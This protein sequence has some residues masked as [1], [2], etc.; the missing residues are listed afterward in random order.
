MKA[1]KRSRTA[2]MAAVI[3]ALH[4]A[5]ES[6]IVFEDQFAGRLAGPVWHF[7]CKSRLLYL[8]ATRTIYKSLDPIRR[9]VLARAR[10]AEDKLEKALDLGI[11][12]YVIIGAGLDSFALR[13]SE[14]DGKINIYELDHPATQ[15]AKKA[16]LKQLNL[17]LPE[18]HEFVPVDFEKENISDA[19]EK[20]SYNYKN[21]AFFSWLGTVHYLSRSAVFKTL[22]A[23]KLCAQAGSELVFDYAVPETHYS[24]K[25]HETV[26]NLKRYTNRR[27]EPILSTF[28]PDIF[29]QQVSKN[30]F[31]LMENLSPNEQAK[32]YFNSTDRAQIFMPGSYFVHFCLLKK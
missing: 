7:L 31:V 3:R 28:D 25:D 14:L 32:R 16:R 12:Q 29:P 4:W 27:G 11:R 13:R 2:E 18:N 8:F 15:K 19:L 26:K 10:Y 21:P 9:Q 17:C 24:H 23:I 6:P 22:T 1:K 20:S 30:G 5:Y